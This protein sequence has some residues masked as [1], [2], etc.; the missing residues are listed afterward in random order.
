MIKTKLSIIIPVYNGERFIEVCLNALVPQLRDDVE[1]I[2]INDGSTDTTDHLIT[3]LFKKH[4]GNNNLIYLSTPNGGVSV[5]RNLGLETAS[6]E[7]VAFVDADDIVNP[8]YVSQI[9]EATDDNPSIIEFGYRTIGLLGEVINDKS[10]IHTHFGKNPTA[11]IINNVFSA[12]LWY[13]FLRVFRRELFNDIRFPIGVRFCEDLI[14]LS[15]IYKQSST[16]YTLAS[17]LY[18]YRINPA[19][20]TFNIKPDYATNL[21]DYYRKVAHDQSFANKAL[22]ANLAYAIRR[23]I[24]STTDKQGR[25][26]PDIEADIRTLLFTPSLFFHIDSRFMIKALWGPMLY[27]VRLLM[28]KQS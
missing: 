28:R 8:S 10:F 22:K 7:Y 11:S 6:G 1:I 23:C 12:C 25:M 27:K 4:Q 14:T 9:L 26:P 16:I 20:A 24:A 18:D 3:T 17:V 15:A 13:P 2:V 21:I 5:A 19:G